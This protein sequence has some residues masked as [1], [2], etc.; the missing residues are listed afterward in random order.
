MTISFA[1]VVA[2]LFFLFTVFLVILPSLGRRQLATARQNA[3]RAL[4]KK[5]GS[6]AES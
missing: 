5:R 2:V 1:G 3:F 6:Q 4:E